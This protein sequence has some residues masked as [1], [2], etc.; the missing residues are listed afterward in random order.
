[1]ATEVIY[2]LKEISASKTLVAAGNYAANDVLSESATEGTAW[3]FSNVANENGR[4]GLIVQA[5]LILSKNGGITAITPRCSLFLFKALPTSNL[6]DNEANTA[7]LDADKANYIGR[8]DFDALNQ[9]G[10]SPTTRA[11]VSTSG[12]LPIGFVC[13][14]ASKTIYGILVLQDAVTDETASTIATI[15]LLV[16]Q[17]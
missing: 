1:M 11:T 14:T 2:K 6:N 3:T 12:G 5:T 16:E 4:G 17:Y 10:G 9:F 15:N 13:L 7:L 8:I